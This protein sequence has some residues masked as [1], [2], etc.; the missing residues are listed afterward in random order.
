MLSIT[1]FPPTSSSHAQPLPKR[2]DL[3]TPPPTAKREQ[4]VA[5][6]QELKLPPLKA[7][8]KD[9][10][11]KASL[12]DT[13]PFTEEVLKPYFD[14]G[15]NFED[16]QKAPEKYMKDFPIRVATVNALVEMRKLKQESARDELPEEFRE[17]TISDA[18]KK[19]ITDKFQ[20]VITTR[21]DI[22]QDAKENLEE[23]AKKRDTEKSKR[24]LA[25]YDYALAQSK[26]R[27]AYI[28]EYNLAL[29]KVKLEQLPE[30][31]PTQT[32]WKLSSQEKMISPKEIRDMAEEGKEALSKIVTDFPNTPWAVM[33][34][35]QRHMVVG[36][37]WQPS[38]F[39]ADKSDKD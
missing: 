7:L 36:L 8:G 6:F 30:L 23:L 16:I 10:A 33:A 17:K 28:Y 25:T 14:D 35:T 13:F 29:G 11:E 9:V 38:S 19:M 20:R 26:I 27:L 15:P 31:G 5:M 18:I 22:L 2:F 24:W 3:P 4:V 32:G 34:K 12:A 21:Q 39:G 37:A 1:S